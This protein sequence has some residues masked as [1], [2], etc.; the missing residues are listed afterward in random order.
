MI[1]HLLCMESHVQHVGGIPCPLVITTTMVNFNVLRI[2]LGGG[3][4]CDIMYVD[5]FEKL[6]L[7]EEM[8]SP[9]QV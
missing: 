3:N 6:G 7:E 1:Y 5:L 9:I 8:L 2:L 4:S